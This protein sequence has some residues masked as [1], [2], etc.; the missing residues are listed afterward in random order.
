MKVAT[1]PGRP[2]DLKPKEFDI[3]SMLFQSAGQLISRE[4]TWPWSG[5]A[6][7]P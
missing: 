3:A 6:N 1:I 5:V 7:W 2:I 4:K